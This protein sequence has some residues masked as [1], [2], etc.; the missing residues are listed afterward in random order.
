MTM[1]AQHDNDNDNDINNEYKTKGLL[2]LAQIIPNIAE[3][4]RFQLYRNPYFY[5]SVQFCQRRQLKSSIFT[6]VK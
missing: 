1:I 4:Y 5:T 6:K 2:E 3:E